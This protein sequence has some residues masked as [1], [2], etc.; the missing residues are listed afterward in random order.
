M[1]KKLK[2]SELKECWVE[3]FKTGKVTDMQGVEHDFSESDLADLNEGIQ[4]QLKNG[5]QPPMVKGHPKLDDPR[6]A[7]IV[8]SKVEGNVLKVKLDDVNSDFAEEVKAGGFKY[9]SS[10]VYGDLKKGLRH[11]GA[12]G[13][14]GPAMKG[15]MP[16]CFGEGMFA[17][18]DKGSNAEDVIVF[19]E[20]FAFDRLVPRSV[21]ESLVY[22][23]TTLG[24][25]FRTQR[26]QMIEKDGIEAAD[27][28]FPEY[29][30]QDIE[31]IESVLKDAKDF[32]KQVTLPEITEV[33]KT[34]D[35]SF[36]EDN[37]EESKPGENSPTEPTVSGAEGN[38]EETSR[39]REE[40]ATL[41]A[42]L[43][44]VKAE[45][46]AAAQ[47]AASAA[48]SEKLD[49]MIKTGRMSQGL[50][51]SLVTLFNALQQMP[52]DSEGCFFS[53]GGEKVNPIQALDKALDS[54]P[55]VV[56][57]GEFAHGEPSKV[58]PGVKI[59]KYREE[60]LAKGRNITFAEAA[61]EAFK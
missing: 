6:V 1:N 40:N 32:P 11:L 53:E 51:E 37:A 5:Y 48:F 8:D 25:L 9:L 43:D 42:E 49:G 2:S 39:L 7:S 35:A 13:A 58:D 36:S 54:L 17:E 55:Q 16:L 47:V 57:F 46:K 29:A 12:L 4:T 30:I 21:F 24:R 45:K 18:A 15:M 3:A 33:P 20:P 56:A 41:K 14:I 10:A 23:L 19:A 59:S 38:S 34:R 26:E 60:Q 22:K 61:E 50:K 44:A 31:G 52:L 28:V 27:K